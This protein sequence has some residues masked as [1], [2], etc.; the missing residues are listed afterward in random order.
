M[1]DDWLALRDNVV[2]VPTPPF[3]AK[4][5]KCGNGHNRVLML[6]AVGWAWTEDSEYGS[7]DAV[8]NFCTTCYDALSSE[9]KLE[10]ILR[11]VPPLKPEKSVRTVRR[12]AQNGRQHRRVRSIPEDLLE[13]M[14]KPLQEIHFQVTS[15]QIEDLEGR[16]DK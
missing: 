14:R 1:E 3:L 10:E 16:L 15:E 4:C 11:A 5:T 6:P 2:I 9:E 8:S 13:A 7:M 12:A